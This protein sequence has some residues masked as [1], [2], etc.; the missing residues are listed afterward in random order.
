MNNNIKI[1]KFKLNYSEFSS[2]S[3][4]NMKGGIM[5]SKSGLY[6]GV[7]IWRSKLFQVYLDCFS[8]ACLWKVK[9]LKKQK[10]F[11]KS[12]YLSKSLAYK[13]LPHKIHGWTDKN[14]LL[15]PN[16]FQIPKDEL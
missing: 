4:L 9:H 8:N 13:K 15:H 11:Y 6:N 16:L 3:K 14:S 5:L 10:L 7:P 12:N 1:S 2:R